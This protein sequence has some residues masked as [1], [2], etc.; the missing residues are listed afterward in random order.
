MM[1]YAINRNMESEKFKTT[2]LEAEQRYKETQ[3]FLIR[4]PLI[5]DVFKSCLERSALVCEKNWGRDE[6]DALKV[7]YIETAPYAHPKVFPNLWDHLDLAE[8]FAGKLAEKVNS[9]ELEPYEAQ[10]LGVLHDLEVLAVP[11]RYLRKTL[12]GEI[13][14]KEVGIRKELLDKLPPIPRIIGIRNP[15]RSIG[16]LSLPQIVLDCA[17]N[18]SKLNPNGTLKT[19]EEIMQYGSAQPGRYKNTLFASERE[20]IRQLTEGGKQKFAIDLLKSEMKFLKDKHGVDFDSL[21]VEVMNEFN[22]DEH[23]K[24]RAEVKN[25]QETLDPQVDR[26]LQRP[27]VKILVYDVGGVLFQDAD[28]E[29]I[30]GLADCYQKDS[31][32]VSEALGALIDKSMTGSITNEE[33]FQ[34]F[35]KSLGLTDAEIKSLPQA[36]IRPEIYKPVPGMQDQLEKVSQNPNVNFVLLS[37]IIS[38][39]AATALGRLKHFYPFVKPENIHFSCDIKASKREQGSK[40]FAVLLNRLGNPNSQSVVFID[41]REKYTT[42]ARSGYNIR[43][44]TFRGNEFENLTSEERVSGELKRAG[45]I[46]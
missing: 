23:R 27:P 33:F 4:E 36:F 32:V 12:V 18:L 45:I 19:T 9:H 42:A 39:L 17:D 37:D 15:I 5:R 25:A 44:L 20:G 8:I 34:R 28:Q 13:L 30:D 2:P 41:D 22:S 11:H 40:S 26:A 38:P 46:D 31:E 3:D 24:W 1:C 14:L 10:A 6:V 7:G 21:R 29:L 43:A 35:G 16:D